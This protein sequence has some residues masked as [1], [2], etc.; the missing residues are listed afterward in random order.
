MNDVLAGKTGDI[1]TGTTDPSPFHYGRTL[2]VFS[3]GPGNVLAGFPASD[4]KVC[5][6]FC[7]KHDDLF[8]ET[9]YSLWNCIG[10]IAD[11]DR[12]QKSTTRVAFCDTLLTR[13]RQ[14]GVDRFNLVSVHSVA[15]PRIDAFIDR[16]THSTENRRGFLYPIDPIRPPL[17]ATT[18][19]YRRG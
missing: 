16:R 18:A 19:A 9:E 5:V 6:M 3:Q 10:A 1:G 12:R 17:K 4:N 13:F 11:D 8:S 15:H 7:F 2:A 14:E